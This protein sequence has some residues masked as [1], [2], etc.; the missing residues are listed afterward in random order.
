MVYDVEG[1]LKKDEEIREDIFSRN[2]EGSKI[3]K[4]EFKENFQVCHRYRVKIGGQNTGKKCHLIVECSIKVR[5]WE[6][7]GKSVH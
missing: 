2:M 6:E 3:R 5:N 1:L 7:K 4:N